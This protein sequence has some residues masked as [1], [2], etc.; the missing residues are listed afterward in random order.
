VCRLIS[1]RSAPQASRGGG[2]ITS[3][4][5]AYGRYHPATSGSG[6]VETLLELYTPRQRRTSTRSKRRYASLP[7]FHLWN[8]QRDTL[9]HEEHKPLKAGE[10]CLHAPN[11]QNPTFSGTLLSHPPSRAHMQLIPQL[12]CPGLPLQT[13]PPFVRCLPCVL[14]PTPTHTTHPE[15]CTLLRLAACHDKAKP[16]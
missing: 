2:A 14:G 3:I 10:P 6:G 12:I 13:Q 16:H 5:R 9:E 11:I 4:Q 1:A 15:V 7:C 8:L